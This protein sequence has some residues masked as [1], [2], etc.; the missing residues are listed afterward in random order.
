MVLHWTARL[1]ILRSLEVRSSST[2]F[3]RHKN[4]RVQVTENALYMGDIWF[5][6]SKIN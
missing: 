5:V 4:S 3:W 2:C 6:P 1:Q